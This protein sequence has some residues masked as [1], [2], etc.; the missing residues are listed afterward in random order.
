MCATRAIA[1]ACG[2]PG[3]HGLARYYHQW[4]DECRPYDDYYHQ[5]MFL[6]QQLGLFTAYA[7]VYGSISVTS[8]DKHH[9]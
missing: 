9:I 1:G 6:G 5:R 2:A 4:M 3:L 7:C 8:T